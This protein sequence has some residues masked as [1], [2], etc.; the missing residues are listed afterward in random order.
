MGFLQDFEQTLKEKCHQNEPPFCT[1]ACPFGLDVKDLIKKWKKGRFNAA[2]RTMQNTVGFPAIVAAGCGHPCTEACLRCGKDGAVNLHLLEQATI[3]YAG[4]KKPNSYNL[5]RKDKKIAVVG[6][7]ISGLACTLLLCNKKY[8]VTVFEKSGRLGGR[9]WDEMDPEIFLADIKNQFMYEKYELHLEHEIKSTDELEGFDAVYIATGAG[10]ADFGLT[11]AD[12]GAYAADKAGFFI[13]GSLY[14][15]NTMEALAD[16]MNA[17]HAIERYLKTGLMNQPVE[18]KDTKLRMDSDTLDESPSVVP[19]NGVCYTEAEA[20]Q[21]AERCV[22]CSCDACMRECDL[23]R[24]YEKTPRRIYEEVYITIHPGTLSRDGTW[25]TRLISTCNQ[26]GLCKNVC[27]QRIDIGEFFL[28]SHQAMHDKGAMPWAFHDYWLRDMVFSDGEAAGLFRGPDCGDR[29]KYVFFPG[30]QMGA[31]DP[32]YVERSFEWLLD[33]CPDSALWLRCCGAPAEWA[34]DQELHGREITAIRR[35]WEQLG[36][37]EIIFGCP[38]CRKMFDKYLPEINRSFLY[39]RMAEWGI[40]KS[41]SIPNGKYSIFDP[42]A[43]QDYPKLQNSIRSMT[44]EMAILTE[45]LS[46]EGTVARCCSYGGQ[47]LI[48]AN[49]YSRE[50]ARDRI[51]END[52]TYIAYCVN[53]RDSFAAQKKPVYHILDLVFGL[54]DENRTPPTLTERWENRRSLRFRMTEQYGGE[55]R[56]KRETVKL[57][58]EEALRRRLSAEMILESDIEEVIVWCEETGHKLMNSAGHMVGHKKIQN[59]TY[60]AEYL[61]EGEGYRLFTG[62]AHRMCLE[63]EFE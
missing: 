2:Y 62:Y 31:S 34:G 49:L 57:Y 27:P 22:L 38:T 11:S 41:A 13:G 3:A 52:N 42:C 35:Q 18:R 45:P 55:R 25:A 63:E 40:E 9:L 26:C 7:G 46:H 59:M 51:A 1:V 44:D 39:E 60:W 50:V 10:G 37:P 56:E 8:E 24:L 19:E 15:K 53:C 47:T 23:M 17:S 29:L 48:A 5:P 28:Q 43:S 20:S 14:G 30:C 36:R 33:K 6:G 4:R 16:G 21:E 12:T 54:N 61:P 58:M 32:Q